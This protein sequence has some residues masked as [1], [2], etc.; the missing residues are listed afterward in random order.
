VPLATF[1]GIG[2]V[3]LGSLPG[4]GALGLILGRCLFAAV[5]TAAVAYVRTSRWR[6]WSYV[7]FVF[8]MYVA[9]TVLQTVE[10]QAGGG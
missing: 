6:F 1:L 9:L 2:T 4:G 10:N 5:I 8:L 7:L 3:V